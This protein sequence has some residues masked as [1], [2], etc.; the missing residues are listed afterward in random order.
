MAEYYLISQLPSLDGVGE[1]G[2]PLP[3]SEERL[4]ELCARFLGKKAQRVLAD[5][6]LA[7]TQTAE[8]SGSALVD[9]WNMA[10]RALRVALA[11]LRAEAMGKPFDTGG[12]VPS[13]ALRQVARTALEAQSPLEAEEYLNRHR[14]DYLE[15][16]RPMDAFSEEFVFYYALRLKL[17]V[18][19]RR[20]DT[21]RGEAAYHAIYR[22]IV[23]MDRM[24]VAP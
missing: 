4:D 7:P 6:T 16:L 9:A 21:E 20:L 17:L 13:D 12:V 18:R 14:L 24:E 1:E 3:M 2:T 15:S 19:M 23:T 10:E 8:K 11:C 22:S 5:L